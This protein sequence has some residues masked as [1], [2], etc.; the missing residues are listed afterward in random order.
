[1]EA[2]YSIYKLIAYSP[3]GKFAQRRPGRKEVDTVKDN[4]GQVH[5]QIG[6]EEN[7]KSN[8]HQHHRH[9]HSDTPADNASVILFL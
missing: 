1:M 5:D 3:Q 2:N 8:E 9:H 7:K 6:G 4:T